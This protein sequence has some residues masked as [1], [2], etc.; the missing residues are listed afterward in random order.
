MAAAEALHIQEVLQRVGW[1]K[2]RAAR[3]LGIARNTLDEKIRRH[4]LT[5]PPGVQVKRG[6]R[7]G[8]R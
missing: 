1:N 5:P 7:R 4:G 2:T 3:V 8:S 6:R